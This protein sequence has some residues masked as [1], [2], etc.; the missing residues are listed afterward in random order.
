MQGGELGRVRIPFLY[1]TFI[2][3]S[4]IK[5][6]II[7]TYEHSSLP[8]ETRQVFQVR[9]IRDILSIK[10]AAIKLHRAKK[11]HNKDAGARLFATWSGP[12][13]DPREARGEQDV[14]NFPRWLREIERNRKESEQERLPEAA[15]A[16]CSNDQKIQPSLPRQWWETYR[17]RFPRNIPGK[18]TNTSQK[19]NIGVCCTNMCSTH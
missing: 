17:R 7:S 1:C 3:N 14:F 11:W 10:A 8:P 12:S 13:H 19:Q 9:R 5:S 18:P 6:I 15:P 2:Y 16:C 4:N